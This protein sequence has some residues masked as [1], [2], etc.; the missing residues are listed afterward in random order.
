[1]AKN[2]LKLETGWL[3]NL[4]I[5]V[6]SLGGNVK[7]VSGRA[8]RKAALQVQT[9]TV[10][11]TAKP[12]L[13]ASGEYSKGYTSESIIHFPKVEWD[14]NVGSV[15]IGFDFAKP[16]A[17]GYLISGTPRMNPDVELRKMYKGKRYMGEINKIMQN[18]VYDELMK[19]WGV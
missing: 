9:D 3:D 15:N 1:M 17:G 10:L 7:D 8:L 14:G 2:I 11:A 16:G 4:L 13:P 5:Q 12:K 19:L 6:D 18:E